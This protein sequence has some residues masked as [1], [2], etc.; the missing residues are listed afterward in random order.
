MGALLSGSAAQRLSRFPFRWATDP[1]R[2]ASPGPVRGGRGGD[3]AGERVGT[4]HAKPPEAVKGAFSK[5][6]RGAL[7]R[8]HA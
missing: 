6:A 7:R 2:G 5:Q 3:A 4:S 1:S 8:F